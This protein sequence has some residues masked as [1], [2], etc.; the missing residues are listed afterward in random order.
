M[1]NQDDEPDVVDALKEAGDLVSHIDQSLAA[2][3]TFFTC[4]PTVI[5]LQ[6]TTRETLFF[7]IRPLD[8]TGK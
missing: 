5:V 6:L 4:Q 1:C 2:K 7:D 3:A 8:I